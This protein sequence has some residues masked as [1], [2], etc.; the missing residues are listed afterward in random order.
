MLSV[1]WSTGCVVVKCSGEA[2][3]LSTNTVA[4]TT[5]EERESSHFR[6]P[7]GCEDREYLY[8]IAQQGVGF[9]L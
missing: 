2:Q 5:V 3:L 9:S 4:V 8:L 7:S 6:N 1:G